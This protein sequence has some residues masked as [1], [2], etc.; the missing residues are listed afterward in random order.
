[1]NVRL[2]AIV[3]GKRKTS[4]IINMLKEIMFTKR[5]LQRILEVIKIKK[6]STNKLW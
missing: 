4:Y 3:E 5:T 6:D 2:S 1:M